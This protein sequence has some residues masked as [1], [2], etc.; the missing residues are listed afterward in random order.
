MLEEHLVGDIGPFSPIQLYY[1]TT[2]RIILTA[3]KESPMNWKV[4]FDGVY[5]SKLAS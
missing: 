4:N 5:G 1:I 3:V 2:K